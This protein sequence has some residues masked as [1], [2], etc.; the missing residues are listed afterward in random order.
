MLEVTLNGAAVGS[1]VT[2]PS[3]VSDMFKYD[4]S[5]DSFWGTA[6]SNLV[7]NFGVNGAQISSMTIAGASSIRGVCVD[8]A[9]NTLWL[10][11]EGNA[12]LIH[13]GR[14][15]GSVISTTSIA[16]LTT[17]ANAHAFVDLVRL[18][19]GTFWISNQGTPTTLFHVN[20]AGTAVLSSMDVSLYEGNNIRGLDAQLPISVS[21]TV[22]YMAVGN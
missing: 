3:A 16:N 1:N 22:T 9:D 15:Q 10:I 19:D 2:V 5:T 11:D 7:T 13:S 14:T 20:A 12:N 4:P 18:P 17:S 8:P 6:S 21:A